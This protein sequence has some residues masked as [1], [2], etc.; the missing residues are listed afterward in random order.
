[1]AP[2]GAGTSLGETPKGQTP[3]FS[4][5]TLPG[6]SSLLLDG[7]SARSQLP[8]PAVPPPCPLTHTQGEPA[9]PHTRRTQP[10]SSSSSSSTPELRAPALPASLPWCLA[11]PVCCRRGH[12]IPQPTSPQ[13]GPRPPHPGPGQNVVFP[14]ADGSLLSD[15]SL[16][17]VHWKMRVPEPPSQVLIARGPCIPSCH[18]C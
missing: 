11:L 8:I 2:A 13:W 14:T 3:E 9:Q 18:L 5:C 10:S 16:A 6:S 7:D 4:A 15:S 1:M 12:E 17:Q